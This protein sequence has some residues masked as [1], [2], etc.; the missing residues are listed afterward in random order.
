[1]MNDDEGDVSPIGLTVPIHDKMN[2]R[3]P[4]ERLYVLRI[5]HIRS[6]VS[7]NFNQPQSINVCCMYPICFR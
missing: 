1:M 5:L 7:R 4:D 3:L 6:N 2:L